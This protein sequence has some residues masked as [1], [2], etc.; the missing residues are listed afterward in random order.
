MTT[1]LTTAL[2]TLWDLWCVP[3]SFLPYGDPYGAVL[4]LLLIGGIGVVKFIN[5]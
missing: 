1:F 5:A 3:F 2:A 4:A